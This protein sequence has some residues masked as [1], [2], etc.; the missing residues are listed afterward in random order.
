[1]TAGEIEAHPF[2]RFEAAQRLAWAAGCDV[3]AVTMREMGD[4]G[5]ALHHETLAAGLR[6]EAVALQPQGSQPVSS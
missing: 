4:E 6:R 5:A 2:G 3:F 1:M